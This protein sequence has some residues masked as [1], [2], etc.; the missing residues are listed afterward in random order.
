MAYL[1]VGDLELTQSAPGKWVAEGRVLDGV[2]RGVVGGGLL[3]VVIGVGIVDVLKGSGLQQV[4]PF[5]IVGAAVGLILIVLMLRGPVRQLL[6]IDQRA[7][8]VSVTQSPLLE[9]GSKTGERR[10]T[11]AL[12]D[13]VLVMREATFN[14]RVISV[15]FSDGGRWVLSFKNAEAEVDALADFV[16]GEA[17]RLRE[18]SASPEASSAEPQASEAAT[19]DAGA[20][21]AA[22]DLMLSQ[23]RSSAFWSI[24]LGLVQLLAPGL[25]RA[26]G[27]SLLLLGALAFLLPTPA[28][29]IVNIVT[30][31]W[32]AGG[33][34]LSGSPFWI[35][36]AGIQIWDGVMGFR[37]WRKAEQYRRSVEGALPVDAREARARR[38]F[39]WLA[40]G[41]GIGAFVAVIVLVA[42]FLGYA[43]VSR[44]QGDSMV[45]T[46]I[47]FLETL[48]VNLGVVG[49][50]LGL[51]SLLA[52]FDRKS[53]AAVG[54]VGGVAALALDF[55]LGMWLNSLG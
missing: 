8:A 12:R 36:L 24:G 29:R 23:V 14:R 40:L 32:V 19:P 7:S 49:F 10:Q 44:G 45:F 54:M 52:G 34:A 25:S 9:G 46:V 30:F 1:F 11:R 21:R 48:V 2:I 6:E 37:R 41:L 22:T 50:A 42:S 31:F 3:A 18:P 43:V 5:L 28:M 55:G 15:G 53:V 20:D 17:R 16:R 39:P 38:F 35:G 4:L 26:W 33:N 27:V 51:A 13:V 47:G